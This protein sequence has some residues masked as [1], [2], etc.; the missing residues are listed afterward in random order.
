MS[1]Q[2]TKTLNEVKLYVRDDRW[3]LNFFKRPV[4]SISDI[5]FDCA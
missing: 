1:G 5:V 4:I 3:A 2:V